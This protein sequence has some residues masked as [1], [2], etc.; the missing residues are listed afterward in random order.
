MLF[1]LLALP[2][3]IYHAC[4]MSPAWPVVMPRE[5]IL[6]SVSHGDVSENLYSL[7][8]LFAWSQFKVYPRSRVQSHE[9]DESCHAYS[10][11][12]F[13]MGSDDIR[14]LKVER[15]IFIWQLGYRAG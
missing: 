15:Y 4:V 3:H 11:K 8:I 7:L 9:Y 1:S 5:V 2:Q 14:L 10:G 6:C 12:G 13:E